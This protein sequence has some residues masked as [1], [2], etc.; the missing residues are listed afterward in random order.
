MH[1]VLD[2]KK[3]SIAEESARLLTLERNFGSFGSSKHEKRETSR[4]IRERFYHIR[5]EKMNNFEYINMRAS[6]FPKINGEK[7][8]GMLSCY[9]LHCDPQLS[10]YKAALRR[11]PCACSSC[12]AKLS[13]PWKENVDANLQPRFA[14]NEDCKYNKIFGHFNDW[15]IIDL[16]TQ[17]NSDSN[18]DMEELK[19]DALVGIIDRIAAEIQVDKVGAFMYD[20][21]DD[22]YGYDLVIW[23]S[24][25]Y[26][27]Q[28]DN[29]LYDLKKGDRVANVTNL[30]RF[31]NRRHFYYSSET[32]SVINIRHV[33]VADVE[34]QT[35][36]LPHG[37]TN[38]SIGENFMGKMTDK[39]HEFILDEINRRDRLNYEEE[40]MVFF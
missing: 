1:T 33:V 35:D 22:E 10:L 15:V 7:Y 25:P 30:Y 4:R 32:K 18:E 24:L 12:L 36:S 3:V 17:T 19:K 40:C 29:R 39:C 13:L 9:H 6:G 37:Y 23:N 26:T 28:E 21:I 34:M 8:N 14:H 31:K 11:I 2:D 5:D 27:L 16:T 38:R 20:E